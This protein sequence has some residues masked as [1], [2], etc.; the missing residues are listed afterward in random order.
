MQLQAQSVSRVRHVH[1]SSLI[2]AGRLDHVETGGGILADEMGMG[3][4]LSMLALILRT[5]DMAYT[6]ATETSASSHDAPDNWLPNSRSKATLIVASSDRECVL[7]PRE[8]RC[9]TQTNSDDQRMVSRAWEVSLH[10]AGAFPVTDS[11]QA[12]RYCQQPHAEDIQIPR[13]ETE[14]L[15]GESSECRSCNHDV[16]YIS[17]RL[18]EC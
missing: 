16:P 18:F 6:W 2:C 13:S 14:M 4:S 11:V 3:K 10:L 8:D 15:C 7:Y 5:L 12:L 1:C 9:L 17:I